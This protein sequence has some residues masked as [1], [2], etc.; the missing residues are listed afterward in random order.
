MAERLK[1]IDLLRGLA[2][3]AV[4]LRHSDDR[5]LLGSIGV[6]IFFVISGFV[7]AQLYRKRSASQFLFDRAWRIFPI[8]LVAL[9]PWL[10]LRTVNGTG[11]SPQETLASVLLIPN[12]FGMTGTYLGVAWTLL[13]ELLFY[14]GV[15]L[16]IRLGSLFVPALLFAAALLARPYVDFTLLHFL[17]SPMIFEF[18]FGVAIACLPVRRLIGVALLFAGA[19]WLL[20][21]PNTG[22][23]DYRV[24]MSYGPAVMRVLLWGLPAAAMVYGML[25]L[26]RAFKGRA[27]DALLVLGAASYSIYLI[28]TL[29]TK[30]V[31]LWWPAEFL[32]ALAVGIGLWWAVERPLLALKPKP[33]RKRRAAAT[34]DVAAI[35]TI[36]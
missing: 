29:I 24:A 13:F 23:E 31:V 34:D 3:S 5:F 32:I 16:A 33:F 30:N 20:F 25:T 4:V 2:A 27:V 15:A 26:E 35:Q 22:L 9:L 8:Y 6:D 7:M 11:V 1:S 12:W 14:A 18:L 21:F 10:I 17:G 28:H 19:L 36:G